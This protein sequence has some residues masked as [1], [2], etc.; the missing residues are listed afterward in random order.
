M[1]TL[2]DCLELSE[3]SEEEILAIAEHEHVPEI[4]DAEPGQLDHMIA[5]TGRRTVPQIFIGNLH[6]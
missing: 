4:V 1:L 5:K 3:L 2:T 6:V